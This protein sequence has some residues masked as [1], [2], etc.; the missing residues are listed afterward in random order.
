MELFLIRHA[1]AEDASLYGDDGERPL[2]A[3]GRQAARE[4]GAALARHGVGFDALVTSPLVRAVETAELIAVGVGYPGALTVDAALEP[5]GRPRQLVERSLE[6]FPEGRVALVGHQPS[7]GALA[8]AL[9]DRP[10]LSLSQGAVVRLSVSPGRAELV[11]AIKPKR[12][13]PVASVDGI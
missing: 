2:T 9:L 12:L 3:G 7:M 1:H 10:G 11:W 6:R 8:S 4:V 5:G 13:E